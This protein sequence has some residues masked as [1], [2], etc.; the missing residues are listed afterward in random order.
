MSYKNKIIVV[1]GS[2]SGIGKGAAQYYATYGATVILASR[3]ENANLEL[4]E[5]IEGR[6]GNAMFIKTD[7]T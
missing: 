2:S 7:V 5:E 1:T 6:G 3:N 4:K